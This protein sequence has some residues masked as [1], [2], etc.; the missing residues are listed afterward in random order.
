VDETAAPAIVENLGLTGHHAEVILSA[1]VGE[2][3]LIVESKPY[4]VFFQASPIELEMLTPYTQR[5][6]SQSIEMPRR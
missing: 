3:V 5:P 1:G 2:G 6:A 4:H